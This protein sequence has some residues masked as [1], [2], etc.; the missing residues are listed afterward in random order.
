MS[1]NAGKQHFLLL[2][3][4]EHQNSVGSIQDLRTG[5]RWFDPPARPIFFLWIDDNHCNRIDSSLTDDHV[6]KQPV[7]WE[8][9]CVEYWLNKLQEI[10]DRCTIKDN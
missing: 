6:G 1:F 3:T 7:G 2:I 10:I 4:A 9:Y 5:G 8:E